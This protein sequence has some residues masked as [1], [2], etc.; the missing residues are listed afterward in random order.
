M[1]KFIKL[2][3]KDIPKVGNEIQWRLVIDDIETLNKYH[4]L[5][6][7]LNME[8]FMTMERE[9]NGGDIKLSHTGA[10]PTRAIMLQ[11]Y[12]QAKIMTTP[13]NE[14]VYPIIEVA[15]LTD[16]KYLA[17]FKYILSHGA[18]QINPS[19]GYCGLESFINTWNADILEEL[20]KDDFGFPIEE[21]IILADTIILENSH[22]DYASSGEWK[23]NKFVANPGTIKTIYHLREMDATYVFKCVTA[24]KN[25]VIE[26]Q[27]L[28]NSQLDSFIKMFLN[29]PGKNIYLILS[30][31]NEIKIKSHPL[32]EQAN[33]IHN[34]HYPKT[35]T[36]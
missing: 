3:L 14:K 10:A 21:D 15:S 9:P 20:E 22:P 30:K 16:R 23:A 6:A 32:Y 11:T 1:P 7:T 34:I 18:I 19:G 13:A 29:V 27:L 24:C 35:D 4:S 31:E 28:D 8:A 26:S 25:V 17:M 5:D 33:A 36:K 2:L 12:L